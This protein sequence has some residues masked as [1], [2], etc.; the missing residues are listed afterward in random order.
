MSLIVFFTVA[1]CSVLVAADSDLRITTSTGGDRLDA[2]QHTAIRLLCHVPSSASSPVTWTHNG[3]PVVA[4]AEVTMGEAAEGHEAEDGHDDHTEMELVIEEAEQDHAGVYKCRAGSAESASQ[5]TVTVSKTQHPV[6]V[7]KSTVSV[8]LGGDL[9]LTCEADMHTD[10]AWFK[11]EVKITAGATETK[12]EA[13]HVKT[14]T[15]RRQNVVGD[16]A[17][18]YSCRNTHHADDSQQTV[19]S[20]GS[21]AGASSLLLQQMH[22]T[23]GALW[24]GFAV[25]MLL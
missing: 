16:D 20:I 14:L 23:I 4:S 1:L 3:S 2:E 15:L 25:K 13:A 11:G 18:V 24:V 7:A 5:V 6:K 21:T 9:T 17:G 8:A 19:V 12:N 10:L 22:I